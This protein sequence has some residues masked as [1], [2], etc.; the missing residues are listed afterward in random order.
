MWET[1]CSWWSAL[2][3]MFL[4]EQKRGDGR[5]GDVH[6]TDS[7]RAGDG[8]SNGRGGDVNITGG[9]GGSTRPKS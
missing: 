7:I 6:I 3:G 8:G 9:A 4:K 1:L 2:K 5:G